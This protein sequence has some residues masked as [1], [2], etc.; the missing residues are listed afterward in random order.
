VPLPAG[1]KIDG[2]NLVPHLRGAPAPARDALYW[3]YPHYGNQ[4]GAPAAAVRRGDWK[5]VEWLEDNRTELFNLA[6]D[7]GETTDLAPKEPQR[8][9]KLRAELHAWQRQVGA[10]FPVANPTFD[11]ARP[12]GRS[13]ERNPAAKAAKGGNKKD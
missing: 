1:L 6:T 13:A 8:V 12:N 9:E 5:L 2:V 10:K 3:H 11:P 7:L 4:G